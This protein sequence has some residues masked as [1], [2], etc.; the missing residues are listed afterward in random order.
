LS[1]QAQKF[2]KYL[3]KNDERDLLVR[4]SFYVK[5]SFFE[6]IHYELQSSN[7]FFILIDKM[8]LVGVVAETMCYKPDGGFLDS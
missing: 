6:V 1:Y 5:I 3:I 7:L 2:L 4:L 8:A